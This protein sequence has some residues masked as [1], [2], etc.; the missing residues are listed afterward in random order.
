[1]TVNSSNSSRL[2]WLLFLVL[3]LMWGSSYLFIKIGVEAGLPPL[4]LVMGRLLIGGAL[5]FAVVRIAREP[6]PKTLKE[7]AK[8]SVLGFFGIALPFYLITVAEASTDSALAAVLVSPVPL[9]V[10]PMSA[11][12]LRDERLTPAR[13]LGVVVGLIG[14]AILVGFDPASLAKNDFG[15]ELLLVASAVSYAIGGVYAKKYIVGYRPMIPALFEVTTALVMVS[16][17]AFIFERPWEAPIN[18]DSVLSVAWLGLFGSGFAFL[19][20]FR[21]ITNWGATRTSTVAYLMPVVGIILGALVLSEAI[22]TNRLIG[23]ALVIGGV[24]LV[25]VRREAISGLIA[26][27]RRGRTAVA[28]TTEELVTEQR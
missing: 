8:L 4:T 14:V 21:L 17:A 10:I 20:F 23:T 27:R 2:D 5:L 7:Y 12:F 22:T 6:F 24:A 19:I 26:R 25:N 16:V 3:G 18:F 1:M 11:L 9:F 15:A 28:D 13:I